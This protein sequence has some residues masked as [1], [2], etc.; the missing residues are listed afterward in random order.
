MSRS[1]KVRQKGQKTIIDRVRP[2]IENIIIGLDKPCNNQLDVIHRFLGDKTL[3]MLLY[4]NGHYVIGINSAIKSERKKALTL[5][6]ELRHYIKFQRLQKTTDPEEVEAIEVICLNDT[7]WLWPWRKGM[8]HIKYVNTV[9]YNKEEV[10][11][12]LEEN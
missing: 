11:H 1:Y 12:W 5:I 8:S 10:L 3:G 6:T 2:C 4:F 7:K 9:K